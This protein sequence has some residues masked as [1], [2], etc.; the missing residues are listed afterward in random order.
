MLKP[1][2]QKKAPDQI[3][4]QIRDMIYR[5]EFKPG[6]KLMAERDMATF[7]KVGRPTVRAAIQKLIDQGLITSKRGVGTFVLDDVS[8]RENRP[9]LQ[10]LNNEDFA[11]SEFMEVR[12]ALEVKSAE[13]AARRATE[14][15]IRLIEKSYERLIQERAKGQMHMSSDISLH[16]NIAYAGK[17]IVQIQVM[18]SFYDIQY[19][20]MDIAYTQLFSEMAMDDMIFNQHTRIVEAIKKHDPSTARAAM[21]VHLETILEAC[22]ENGL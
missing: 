21:E 2:K 18:K 12:M 15:D 4:E 3:F 13:L 7:F 22:R 14:E 6:Q 1:V 5:G 19:H 10:I 9:L 8:R 16:M 11:I 17:N 20:A